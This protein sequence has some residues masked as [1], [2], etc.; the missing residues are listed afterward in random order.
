MYIYILQQFRT[1]SLG[2]TARLKGLVAQRLEDGDGRL[3]LGRR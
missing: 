2:M 3:G 1:M